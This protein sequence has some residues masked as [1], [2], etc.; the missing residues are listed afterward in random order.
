[1]EEKTKLVKVIKVIKTIG[2]GT[3][4][5]PVRTVI[6]YWSLNGKLLVTMDDY[7]LTNAHASS[8]VN[9]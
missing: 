4:K 3:E 7:S 2:N 6:Q 8:D 1:M 5:N 9:S